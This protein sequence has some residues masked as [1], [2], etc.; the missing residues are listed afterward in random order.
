MVDEARRPMGKNHLTQVV[1]G[2]KKVHTVQFV[3]L[4]GLK[5]GTMLARL[6]TNG[7]MMVMM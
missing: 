7:S 6:L 5:M 3:G 1:N 4:F 2:Q